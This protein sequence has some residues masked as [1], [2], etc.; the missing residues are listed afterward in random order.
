MKTPEVEIIS[1][2]TSHNVSFV[3]CF[4]YTIFKR[5]EKKNKLDD[6]FWFKYENGDMF[7]V[8]RRNFFN[9]VDERHGN[10]KLTHRVPEFNPLYYYAM[11]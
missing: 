11:F 3:C 2:L 10:V 8:R 6:L 7:E 4:G 5:I 1:P 9:F